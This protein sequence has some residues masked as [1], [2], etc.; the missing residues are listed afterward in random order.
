MG[1]KFWR[2]NQ[3]GSFDPA[4]REQASV[5]ARYELQR[6]SPIGKNVLVL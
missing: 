1:W 4:R 6:A 2:R 5:S 3:N